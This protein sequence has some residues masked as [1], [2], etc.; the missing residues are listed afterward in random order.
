MSSPPP[1]RASSLATL[2]FGNFQFPVRLF[3]ATSEKSVPFVRVHAEC[4]SKLRQEYLCTDPACAKH[5]KFVPS[6]QQGR[7]LKAA[8]GRLVPFMDDEILALRSARTDELELSEF[9]SDDAVDSVFFAKT[10]YVVPADESDAYVLLQQVMAKTRTVGLGRFYRGGD[11]RFV[12][13]QGYGEQGLLARELFEADEVRAFPSFPPVATPAQHNFAEAVALV[14]G[15]RRREF[16]P[17][18]F[19]DPFHGRVLESAEKKLVPPAA[20]EQSNVKSVMAARMKATAPSRAADAPIDEAPVSR[21]EMPGTVR[22]IRAKAAKRDDRP[23]EN[24]KTSG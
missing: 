9:V 6:A 15:M 16:R 21:P 20:G 7:A 13:V 22:S 14:E 4:G 1:S 24:M 11:A 23:S 8:G 10:Y 5:E 18:G 3:G 19:T 2:I 17:E 12:L